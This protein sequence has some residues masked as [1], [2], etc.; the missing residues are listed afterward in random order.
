VLEDL[1]YNGQLTGLTLYF[2]TSVALELGTFLRKRGHEDIRLR[3]IYAKQT[4]LP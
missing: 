1:I 2:S 3:N 4:S